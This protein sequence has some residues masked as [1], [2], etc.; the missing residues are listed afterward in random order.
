M[1]KTMNKPMS[2]VK[3][4][5]REMMEAE[6]CHKSNNQ[7]HPNERHDATL[8]WQRAMQSRKD[9]Q[10]M[11]CMQQRIYHAVALP[12]R[13]MPA[14]DSDDAKQI[15]D[16]T[17]KIL[18]RL[19][20]DKITEQML[21]AR[22]YGYAVAEII[23]QQKHNHITIEAIKPRHP[24]Y[25]DFDA[26]GKIHIKNQFGKPVDLPEKKF[27]HVTSGG[28]CADQPRGEALAEWLYAP[29]K[30]KNDAMEQWQIFLEKYASPTI[31]GKYPAARIRESEKTALLEA[32]AN[33][34][35]DTAAVIPDSMMLEL[36]EAKRTGNG[37]YHPLIAHCNASIAKL[38][39]GQ[40]MTTDEGGSYAQANVHDRVKNRLILADC[41]LICESF[42]RQ[43]ITWLCEWN[44]G[45]DDVPIPYLTRH[46]APMPDNT[47]EQSS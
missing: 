20:M 42:T 27:W 9:A 13:V 4:D 30:T 31:I 19:D 18:H 44:F 32:A 39:L 40:T 33:L 46:F 47:K 11:A 37:E 35:R 10:V 34:R 5:N 6:T 1:N 45:D 12:Y 17:R 25:F 36:L 3:F 23:W 26:H 24:Q 29:V 7:Q 8:F 21:W 28:I 16:F 15:A 41:D 38:I 22:Y 14:D 2:N 43:V